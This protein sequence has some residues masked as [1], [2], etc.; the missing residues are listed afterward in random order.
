MV[1]TRKQEVNN[2]TTEA[3]DGSTLTIGVLHVIDVLGSLYSFLLHPR[4]DGL[5]EPRGV[6]KT[7]IATK[8]CHSL[9]NPRFILCRTTAKLGHL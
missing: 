7:T 4:L 1:P 6:N 5:A 8:S 9:L 3:Y 2:P